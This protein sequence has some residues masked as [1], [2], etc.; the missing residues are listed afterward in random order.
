MQSARGRPDRKAL[1]AAGALCLSVPVLGI[2]GYAALSLDKAYVDRYLDMEKRFRFEAS[3]RDDQTERRVFGELK[4]GKS[5]WAGYYIGIGDD[6]RFAHLVINDDG[7]FWIYHSKLFASEGK[8][9]Q[10]PE[11]AD[12]FEGVGDGRM[13]S[14]MRMALRRQEGG[15]FLLDVD[16]GMVPNLPTSPPA[17][18]KKADPPRFPRPPSASDEVRFVGVFSETYGER[19]NGFWLIQVWLW[20]SGGEWWGQYLRDHY[21]RGDRR[22][23]ISPERIY[24]VCSEQCSVL[25]F[26][27]GRGPVTLARDS[28][29]GFTATIEGEQKKVTLKRV[30]KLPGFILDLAP[31]ATKKENQ[32]WIKA[33]TTAGM[34]TWN[35][36]PAAPDAP[37][38]KAQG[39]GQMSSAEA[40]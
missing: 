35:V 18:M 30:E 39:A 15:P 34:I 21:V 33:L 4:P 23:F 16:F 22:E 37:A 10:S 11:S 38:P 6:D 14:R 5:S 1:L 3:F 12:T 8:G 29:G 17:P 13:H 32:E 25:S 24:P 26:K 7:R 9:G 36:P 40:R 19:N 20:E 2:A 31:L 27:S 28:A